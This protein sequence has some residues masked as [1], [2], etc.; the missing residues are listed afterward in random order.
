[1]IS[2]LYFRFL[3]SIKICSVNTDDWRGEDFSFLVEPEKVYLVEKLALI[4]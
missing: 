1:M 2:M 3:G 4:T